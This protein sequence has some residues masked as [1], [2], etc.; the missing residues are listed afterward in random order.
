VVFDSQRTLLVA[1]STGAPR[2]L[3][4]LLH[5]MDSDPRRWSQLHGNAIVEFPG[6][7]PTSVTGRTPATISGPAL[8]AQAEAGGYKSSLAW[9]AA[10]GVIG[11]AIGGLATI[12]IGA[13]R[14]AK[15]GQSSG[16]LRLRR[17][18]KGD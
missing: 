9:L 2:L 6:R 11:V 4:D 12:V 16:R 3:D 1:T 7:T 14:S 5:W 17:R 13:R 8:N 10:A 18:S 15:A